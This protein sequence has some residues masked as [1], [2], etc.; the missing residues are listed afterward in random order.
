[1]ANPT[2]SQNNPKH[3]QQPLNTNHI[4][5]TSATGLPT[6]PHEE[7]ISL[8]VKNLPQLTKPRVWEGSRAINMRSRWIQASKPSTYSPDGYLTKVNGLAWWDTF[9]AYIANDT[10]LATGFSTKDRIWKPDLEW[11]VNANNFAKIID[12]KYNK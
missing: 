8:Y 12:G 3:S 10:S 4:K 6:C 9:F 7:I 11:I 2:E 1:V 5:D